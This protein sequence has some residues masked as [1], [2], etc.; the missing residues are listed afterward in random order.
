MP[1]IA[2]GD[3]GVTTEIALFLVYLIGVLCTALPWRP[4]WPWL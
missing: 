1:A 4:V 3:P 2:L